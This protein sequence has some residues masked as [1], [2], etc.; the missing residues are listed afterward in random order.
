MKTRLNKTILTDP[1]R[2]T[3]DAYAMW[4][5]IELAVGLTAGSLPTLKPLLTSCL[6][7]ARG[8]ATKPSKSSRSDQHDMFGYVRQSETSNQNV[9]L[10]LYGVPG[11]N[12]TRISAHNVDV[13][14]KVLWRQKKGDD[15]EEDILPL[16]KLE[17]QI[18]GIV[19]TSDVRVG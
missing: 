3:H 4:N 13:H 6:D 7:V 10:G 9:A 18:K 1:S 16:Q 11:K 8:V 2:F 17:G 15:G 5:F 14:A 19:V 12:S